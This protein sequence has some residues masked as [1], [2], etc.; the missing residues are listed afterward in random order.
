MSLN[1]A[2]SSVLDSSRRR[3]SIHKEDG[4]N[5]KYNLSDKKARNKLLKGS[6]REPFQV[7]EKSNSTNLVFNLG[8]W[9]KVVMPAIINMKEAIGDDEWVSGS[10]NIRV[11]AVNSGH[12]VT[13]LHVDTQI[14]FFVNRQKAVCHFYNTT[15]RIMIN[16]HGYRSLVSEFFIPYFN[17]KITENMREIDKFNE[18]AIENVCG[19]TVKRS[20]VKLK[21]KSKFVCKKCTFVAG[22]AVGLSK[23]ARLEHTP[24]L[25]L[26]GT[27]QAIEAPLH[28]TRN[29]SD[30]EAMLQESF[31]NKVVSIGQQQIE[32]LNSGTNI[33]VPVQNPIIEPTLTELVDNSEVFS[34]D[35]CITLLSSKEELD[36]H[37]LNVHRKIISCVPQSDVTCQICPFCQTV[38]DTLQSLKVHIEKDHSENRHRE[39]NSC[40]KCSFAGSESV[41]DI[42]TT[43]IHSTA[44]LSCEYCNL[45]VA[46]DAILQE[47]LSSNHCS[48]RGLPTETIKDSCQYCELKTDN[49]EALREHMITCH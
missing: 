21:S 47:H 35:E 17:K 36:S 39:L 33:Q 24:S 8:S 49:K 10:A 31:T 30:N 20:E 4:R 41:L 28:S 29:N 42:H 25:N 14:V 19:K 2:H 13:G 11:A 6:N 15:K 26:N 3:N 40:S 37:L 5:F 12:E 32:F 9:M 7:E 48:T 34:C 38:T 1:V 22:T 18:Q 23:H 46:N 44:I 45:V 27:P 43:E 16:G